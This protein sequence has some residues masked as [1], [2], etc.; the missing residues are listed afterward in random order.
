VIVLDTN[1]LSE[2]MKPA[3]NGLVKEWIGEQPVRSLYTTSITMAEILHG[4]WLLP[5]GKR[6]RAIQDA[7]EEVFGVDFENRVLPFDAPA[8]VAYARLRGERRSAGRPISAFDAQIAAICLANRAS[9]ATRNIA[10][11]EGCG[12][13]LENPWVG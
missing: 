10:D 11:F 12:V 4:V 9:L 8:S 3:P 1:V 7:A 6:R 2:L 13:K 5:A